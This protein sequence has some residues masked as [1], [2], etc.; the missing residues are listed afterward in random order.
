MKTPMK[1]NWGLGIAVTYGV[2]ACATLGFVAFAMTKPV[3]LVSDDYYARS[4]RHDERLAAEGRVRGLG[5]AFAVRLVGDGRT[6]QVALP[7]GAAVDGTITMYRPSDAGSDR[8]VALKPDALGEQRIEL[9]GAGRWVV[10]LQWVA[11]GEP[12]YHEQ[13]VVAR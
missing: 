9:P 3:D 7:A 10:K 12:Y 11:G 2:F 8:F 13:P 1:L 4:L 6:V 5:A